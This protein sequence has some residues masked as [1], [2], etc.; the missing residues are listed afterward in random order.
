MT[1]D[2]TAQLT[3]DLTAVAVLSPMI[4]LVL[5]LA[6]RPGRAPACRPAEA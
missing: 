4:L 1:T 2:T 5:R 3:M 6:L